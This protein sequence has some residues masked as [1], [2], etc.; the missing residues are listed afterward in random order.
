[1]S[2][3]ECRCLESKRSG[4]HSISENKLMAAA[5]EQENF[6]SAGVGN[7]HDRSNVA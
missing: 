5:T 2:E 6:T 1:L 3:R 4:A 7:A